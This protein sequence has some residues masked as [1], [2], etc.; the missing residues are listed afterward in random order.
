MKGLVRTLVLATGLFALS[1]RQQDV[2]TA[3]ITCPQ[4]RNARCAELV[5][6][7]LARTDGVLADSIKVKDG[8]ATVTY[9]S[10]KVAVKNLAFSIAEAGFDADD[11]PA[12][13]KAREA[14]PPECR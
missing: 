14:L 3:T 1:C 13:I 9:D 2:R 4:V 7:A 11:I 6:T 12:D 10:M 5:T 8:V